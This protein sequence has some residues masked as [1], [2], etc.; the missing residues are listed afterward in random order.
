MARIAISQIQEEAKALGWQLISTEYKNL[1]SELTFVCP[2]AHEVITTYSKWRDSHSCPI[3]DA[4]QMELSN[5]TVPKKSGIKRTLALDQA[6]HYTGWAVYDNKTLI[7][8]GTYKCGDTTFISRAVQ[9]KN[10]LHNM[11]VIWK[12]DQ[13][14]LEDI[15]LQEKK[16]KRDWNFDDGNMV[17]NVD[18]FKI[19]AQLQGILECLLYELKYEYAYVY[20]SVWR[21]S[22]KISGKYRDERKKS[23]QLRV[24]EWFDIKVTNDE[25]DAI[26]IGYYITQKDQRNTQLLSWE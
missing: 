16:E 3:C 17:L 21:K 23:A 19:L 8:Y 9:L 13:V 25:A 24:Q 1:N 10:W 4:P 11:L 5:K 6:T 22:C 7:K 12:P 20:P 15:Q 14:I 26:C 18:T 2:N